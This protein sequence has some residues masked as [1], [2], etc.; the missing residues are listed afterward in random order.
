MLFLCA[1][2]TLIMQIPVSAC[3]PLLSMICVSKEKRNF[4]HPVANETSLM[5]AVTKWKH[6]Q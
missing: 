5:M 2:D 3:G 6:H 1:G 4:G